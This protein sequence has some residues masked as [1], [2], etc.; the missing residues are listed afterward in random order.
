M[1]ESIREIT[2]SIIYQLN[3]TSSAASV[4]NSG[5]HADANINANSANSLSVN[6]GG[7][8]K[9]SS[10]DSLAP[11]VASAETIKQRNRIVLTINT[12]ERIEAMT[13]VF[14]HAD[15]RLSWEKCFVEAKKIFCKN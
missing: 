14:G 2:A 1:D 11:Q 10:V 9:N 13:V 3:D 6:V 4:L 12:Q 15:Q 8:N 7:N 5:T